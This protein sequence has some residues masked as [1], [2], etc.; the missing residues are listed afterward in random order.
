[1]KAQGEGEMLKTGRN[2]AEEDKKKNRVQIKGGTRTLSTATRSW[3]FVLVQCG[4]QM[5][6]KAAQ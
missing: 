6:D 1:M 4:R 2:N 5:R 3:E